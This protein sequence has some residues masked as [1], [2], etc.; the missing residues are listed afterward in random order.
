MI[1][2]FFNLSVTIELFLKN[3]KKNYTD[4]RSWFDL[5]KMHLTQAKFSAKFFEIRQEVCLFIYYHSLV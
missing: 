3:K 5:N 4:F 1:I 2:F